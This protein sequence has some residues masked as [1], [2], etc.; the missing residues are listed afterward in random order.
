MQ[1][2]LEGQAEMAG[3]REAFVVSRSTHVLP[4]EFNRLEARPV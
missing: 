1:S 2:V 3:A 4:V